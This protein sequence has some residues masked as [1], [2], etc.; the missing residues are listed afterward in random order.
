MRG[1]LGHWLNQTIALTK[2]N[3][4]MLMRN[5][6]YSAI[7]F[8]GEATT[9]TPWHAGQH[10][11]ACLRRAA[12]ARVRSRTGTHHHAHSLALSRRTQRRSSR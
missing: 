10:D 11:H 8:L 9:L 2:K 6:K 1:A 4:T 5:R 7:E 3:I 12:R